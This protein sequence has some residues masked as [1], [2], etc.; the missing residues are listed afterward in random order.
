M[1]KKSDP[2][3]AAPEPVVLPDVATSPHPTT[4][5]VG[6]ASGDVPRSAEG[7]LEDALP[8][9]NEAAK[10]VGGFE[11]LSKIAGQLGQAQT[12]Q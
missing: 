6:Q 11:N 5:A 4:P 1:D 9:I 10:K 8:E 12:S 2:A 3:V 7:V